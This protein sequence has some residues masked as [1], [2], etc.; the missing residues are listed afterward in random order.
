MTLSILRQ[1]IHYQ[2]EQTYWQWP[3]GISY[4]FYLLCHWGLPCPH[5]SHLLS[6]QE[7]LVRDLMGL[8]SIVGYIIA[9]YWPVPLKERARASNFPIGR[10]RRRMA[11]YKPIIRG[12]E[13]I[14]SRS[15]LSGNAP[16]ISLAPFIRDICPWPT[17]DFICPV[18]LVRR[19]LMGLQS[20][21]GTCQLSL[22]P[23]Q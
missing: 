15:K 20:I 8:Q 16:P 23:A 12:K 18:D 5:D 9:I 4:A 1:R 6:S 22:G 3:P 21:L 10:I 14:S 17:G 2:Q 7:D 11:V 13:R 19:D